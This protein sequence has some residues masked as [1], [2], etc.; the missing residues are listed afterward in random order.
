VTPQ[1]TDDPRA[2]TDTA[3]AGGRGTDRRRGYD[4]RF[5]LAALALYVGVPGLWVTFIAALIMQHQ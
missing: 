1:W 3:A 5:T 4:L 2:T